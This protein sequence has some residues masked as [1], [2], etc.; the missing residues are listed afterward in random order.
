[1]VTTRTAY[2]REH[3]LAE[4]ARNCAS[5]LSDA[6]LYPDPTERKWHIN[7]GEEVFVVLDGEVNMH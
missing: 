1:M 3:G 4:V 6:F 5:N 2:R 7:D